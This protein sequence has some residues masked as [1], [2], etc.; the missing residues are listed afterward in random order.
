MASTSI[1]ERLPTGEPFLV[2]E[3]GAKLSDSWVR[4]RGSCGR[5][6]SSVIGPLCAWIVSLPLSTSQA[7]RPPFTD[8]PSLAAAVAALSIAMVPP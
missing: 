2:I 7:P 8:T 5:P 3:T 4:P 1:D 6:M